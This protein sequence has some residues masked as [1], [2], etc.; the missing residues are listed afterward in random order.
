MQIGAGLQQRWLP[1]EVECAMALRTVLEAADLRHPAVD[2]VLATA[3]T[4]LGMQAVYIGSLSKDE[5][6]YERLWGELQGMDEGRSRARSESMCHRLLAGAAPATADAAHDPSYADSPERAELGIMSY[7]GVP[8]LTANGVDATLCGV[9]LRS[10]PVSGHDLATMRGLA[11]VI[12]AQLGAP[13]AV[14]VR[15]T[16]TGWQVAG[17]EESELLSAIVLADL[18][19]AGL[20]QAGS[21]TAGLSAPPASP[22]NADETERLRYT[23]RQLEHALASRVM[24]EQ[25]IG[26]LAERQRLRPRAAFERLRRAA[27]SRGRRVIDL[28]REVVAST[29]DPSVPLPPELAGRRS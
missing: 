16:P 24:V 1:A 15:R 21:A 20:G 14:V 13:D 10:V 26:V 27:R 4:L 11:R 12:E 18:L 25:A 23:V 5:F 28:A 8:L 2:A 7:V 9:D 6:V 17:T 29:A 22:R 3:A 19:A